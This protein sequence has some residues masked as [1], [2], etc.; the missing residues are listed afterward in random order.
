MT[1]ELTS[2]QGYTSELGYMTL[3]AGL[4]DILREVNGTEVTHDL[5]YV[6]FYRKGEKIGEKIGT[7]KD[8]QTAMKQFIEYIKFC[9]DIEI[10]NESSKEKEYTSDIR[11][12]NCLIKYLCMKQGLSIKT[13]LCRSTQGLIEGAL[14]FM[15]GKHVYLNM[16]ITN[17]D[18]CQGTLKFKKKRDVFHFI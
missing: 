3:I 9:F 11:F 1:S 5:I 7:G 18:N 2:D 14:S 8:P 12:K 16:S 17:G 15:T 10:I 6:N 4:L 13:P